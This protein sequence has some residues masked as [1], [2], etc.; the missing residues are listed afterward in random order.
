MSARDDHPS[1]AHIEAHGLFNLHKQ[2]AAAL[3]EIDR[4]RADNEAW[5]NGVAAAV[6]PLGYNR[7]A[8]NGP[9]DLLP[10]LADLRPNHRVNSETFTRFK[11]AEERA[12]SLDR[13]ATDW[14]M[15][16]DPDETIEEDG[17]TYINP[18]YVVEW[19]E[20]P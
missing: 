12:H 6:E 5:M 4:L 18:V 17:E 19:S 3:D 20:R 11:Y 8:A 9:S 10:G 1:L 16:R 14:I 2:M 15:F 13:H 7:H